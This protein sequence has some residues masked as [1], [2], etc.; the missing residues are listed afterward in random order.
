MASLAVRA[1]A[2]PFGAA[3]IVGLNP[4]RDP[5]DTA[6]RATVR[7]TLAVHGVACVRFDE[8]LDTTTFRR[9]A[10]MFGPIKIPVGRTRDG[11][12]LTYDV[13]MQVIDSGFVLTEELRQQLGGVTFGGD[14]Q[15]PGL[16]ETFH[17][18]DTYV[19]RPAA[20]TIL[21]ARELPRSG[22]GDTRFLD[23]RAAYDLLDAETRTQLKGRFAVYAY[24]NHDAFPPRVSAS[25]PNDALVEVRH[26]IVRRHPV[27]GRAALYI[28]LDRATH[29]DGLPIADGR[30]LL[31]RLQDHAEANAPRHAHRWRPNDVL[32]WDNAAVQH[33]AS[34]DFPV[35]EPRRFYRFLIAGET[36]TAAT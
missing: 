18:D 2:E 10:E 32:I 27:T 21:S 22:G 19:E 34:G 3:E 7:E 28:D 5:D 17:V 15:R 1:L 13:E 30:A 25:G 33:K 11:A 26:P 8:T 35:G 16:F 4:A 6:A 20:A 23:M 29:V 31:Q 36:P 9:V 24:N 12:E 14:A